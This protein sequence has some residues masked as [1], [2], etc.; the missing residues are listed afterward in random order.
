VSED[1][2]AKGRRLLTDG[3]LLVERVEGDLIVARCRGDSGSIY[4]LG[5][6][7]SRA[8]WFCTCAARRR[9]SHLIALMLVVV[10]GSKA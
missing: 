9:C 3:R 7:P 8:D 1:A 10:R 5:F 4:T 2:A 6:D